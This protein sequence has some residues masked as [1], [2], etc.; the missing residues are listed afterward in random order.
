AFLFAFLPFVAVEEGAITGAV[1]CGF[2][3]GWATLWLLSSRLTDQPQRWAAVPALFMGVG[4]LL[5]GAF[6]SPMREAPRWSWP[7]MLFLLVICLLYRIR[8]D[9]H[10]RT[11]R[12]QLY[13]VFGVL[14]LSAVGGG[15][16]TV[17]EATDSNAMPATGRLIDVGGHQLYLSCVGSGSP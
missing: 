8:K 1:L 15:Y 9:M 12:V 14:A 10:S 4:G 16:Q 7:P 3:V 13:L 2:A 11:G 6:G 17:G 5:L